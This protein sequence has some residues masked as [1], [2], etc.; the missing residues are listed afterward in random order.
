[1]VGVA[2]ARERKAERAR[3]HRFGIAGVGRAVAPAVTPQRAAA[4]ILKGIERQRYLVF[5]SFDVRLGWWAQR[6]FPPA[7]EFV[8]RRLNDRLHTL[9]R[10]PAARR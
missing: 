6:C 10:P 3:H 9:A 5:T 7:Y 2:S 4:A 1:M 8:M